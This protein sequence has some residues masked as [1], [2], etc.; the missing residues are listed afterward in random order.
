MVLTYT[1]LNAM[2]DERGLFE[3]AEYDQPREEHG[4]CVDDVARGLLVIQRDQPPSPDIRQLSD[5]YFAFL[6]EAQTPDGLFI[7]RC[8]I[9]GV[10]SGPSEPADHWGRALW[11][12]G[13]MFKENPDRDMANRALER[14]EQGANNRS[15]FLRSMIFAALGSAEVLSVARNNRVARRLLRDTA[16]MVAASVPEP[17]PTTPA[18]LWPEDRL[19]YANAAIPEVLIRAGQLLDENRFLNY[20]L[21]LLAWLI[22]AET[23]GGH[24]SVTPTGGYGP[25][26]VRNTYDQQPIEIA[27]IVDACNTAYDATHD[28]AWLHHITRGY[29]WFEGYN[30]ANVRMFDPDTGA[31][32]DGITA[33]GRNENRGAESTICYL[34]VSHRF[35]QHFPRSL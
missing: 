26:E 15:T 6:C 32:F 23:S 9:E 11:A 14:F 20:G 17:L 29:L 21:D 34:T 13:T 22:E 35:Q 5:R 4:Y 3:H 16:M 2:T 8:D 28:N 30:D 1:H 12:L 7:N 25:D 24:F 31:G 10:W 18:W 27:A 19:T 33:D